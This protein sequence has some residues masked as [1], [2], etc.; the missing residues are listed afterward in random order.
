[1]GLGLRGDVCISSNLPGK[2]DATDVENHLRT[3]ALKA[4]RDVL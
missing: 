3:A 2:A 1:M 4:S